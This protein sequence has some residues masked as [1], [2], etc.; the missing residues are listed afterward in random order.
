[1]PKSPCNA[2]NSI[3]SLL[4]TA[5]LL[6]VSGLGQTATSAGSAVQSSQTFA[7]KLAASPIAN[8]PVDKG[9]YILGTGDQLT[10]QVFGAD[11]LPPRPIEVGPDGKI[12][13]PMVGKVQAAGVSV[14]NLETNLTA[15]YRVYFKDPQVA[16]SVTDYRSEPVTVV[17]AV[18]NPSVI[19]LR[20]PTRLMQAISMAGGLRADAGDKVLIT[21]PLQAEQQGTTSFDPKD[22]NA[23]FYV[24]PVDL[25]NII[26]GTDPSTNVLIEANDVIT[27]PK[28]K[29]VYVVGAVGRPGG[30]VL[31]GHSSTLSVLQAIALAGG[32]SGTAA[33]GKARIL[34]ATSGGGDRVEAMVNLNKIMSSKSP[35]LPLHAD[36]ILFVPTSVAKNVGLRTL[37][38]G[39]NVG[40]GLA[41][42]HF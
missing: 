11:D 8:A 40:T 37:E 26:D 31:D 22:P 6:A 7:E 16:V 25:E 27:V 34:H 33:G 21:R 35:D 14:R 36:D 32:T 23:K 39:I 24:K 42:W 5:P 19:Q 28:A 29:M 41:I 38:T 18:N 13:V 9:E 20:G 2:R 4:L 3:I 1:M 17:G 12:N 15:R 30:Y 10:V